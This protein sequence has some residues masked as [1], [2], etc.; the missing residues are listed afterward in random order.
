M[1]MAATLNGGHFLYNRHAN[2]ECLKK[3]TLFINAFHGLR[4]SN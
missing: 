3:I 1:A 4:Y 2:I